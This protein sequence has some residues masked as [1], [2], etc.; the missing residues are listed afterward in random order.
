MAE[1]NRFYEEELNY[2]IE[3]G[4][5]YARLH[6]DRANFLSL[7]DP[8]HRDPHVERLVEAFAFLTGNVRQKLEDDFPELT[9]SFLSLV[10]PYHLR[11]IP[12]M[13]MLEFR[14]RRG[15]LRE[16]QVIRK[17]FEVDSKRTSREVSCRFRTA[18]AVEIFPFQLTEAGF[19]AGP[20]GQPLLRL[21]FEKEEGADASQ[22]RVDRLRIH[23]AG[24][25][26]V[27][28]PLYRLLRKTVAG[29]ALSIG[30]GKDNKDNKDGKDS[31]T[32]RLLAEDCIRAVGFR[33]GE[34]VLPY[35]ATSFP[36]Y[37][38]LAE[39]FCF[40]E[41]FLF[42]DVMGLGA[43]PLG[44]KDSGF[45]LE[46]RFRERP[47]ESLHPT[48]ENFRLYV[49]PIVNAFPRGGEPIT[50]TQLKARYRILGDY[51]HPDAY[52]VFSVDKVEG[53][54][55]AD[56]ARFTRPPFFS[57][58]HDE[59][60]RQA[61]RLGDLEGGVF[62]HVTHRRA[63]GGEW[64]THLSLI[65]ATP[66]TLPGEEVLSLNLTCTNG[67]LPREVGIGDVRNVPPLDFAT[68]QNI[69]RPTDPIYPRLGGGTEWRFV[70]QMALNLL[71]LSDP[72]ALR[73]LLG[74]YDPGELP[75]NRRRIGSVKAAK[76]TP[77]EI[78]DRGAPIRGTALTLTIDETCFDDFGDLL[79]FG[80][81][82]GEFLSLY[83][84]VNSFTEL[85]L[86]NDQNPPREILRCQSRGRQALI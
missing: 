49:T 3:A 75:A 27:A 48:A 12:S 82:L 58:A 77:R 20:G 79:I 54:R 72:P 28:F 42:L 26:S 1:S 19:V 7:T 16:P 32:R 57:F 59:A 41:K 30:G 52:E 44:P 66:G 84:A 43:V 11:P 56:G 29:V 8:R 31:R 14:P 78:L 86:L 10:W 22:L 81:V 67:R 25:P 39:Y 2:L 80:E 36:G 53:L 23:L 18:Y 4:R 60:G 74:L 33:E 63:P 50:V 37:R 55:S 35:P 21:H 71:S 68:F 47:P 45:D 13:A 69:T 70:S 34:E 15:M 38:L 6:P 85:I 40:P 76:L 64:L 46:I 62:H 73:A 51:T 5:E 83:S 65:S 24:E 9:H 61:E 17:G